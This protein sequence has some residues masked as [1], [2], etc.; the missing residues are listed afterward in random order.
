[1]DANVI[2]MPCLTKNEAN[3][4][5]KDFASIASNLDISPVNTQGS[6]P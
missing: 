1:M 5:A 6:D 3:S 4:Y 2:T